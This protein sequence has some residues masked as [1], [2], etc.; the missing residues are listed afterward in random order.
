MAKNKEIMDDAEARTLFKRILESRRVALAKNS[1]AD[2]ITMAAKDAANYWRALSHHTVT[3]AFQNYLSHLAN[4]NYSGVS[5][6]GPP[7]TYDP[8]ASATVENALMYALEEDDEFVYLGLPKDVALKLA[9]A[10]KSLYFGEIQK[11]IRPNKKP[12]TTP[13]IRKNE[14]KHLAVRAVAY[15]EGQ[16]S[17]K[18]AAESDVGRAFG[19]GGQAIRKWEQS[20]RKNEGVGGLHLIIAFAAGADDAGFSKQDAEK[21]YT[22]W[23]RH[24]Q[25]R[26]KDR[27]PY[28]FSKAWDRRRE[29]HLGKGEGVFRVG[30]FKEAGRHFQEIDYEHL[31]EKW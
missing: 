14:L 12:R 13:I 24:R 17:K 6:A 7:K 4:D 3:W 15:L 31:L 21:K 22:T 16:G 23:A 8:Q 25:A 29:R 18:A 28:T 30:Q 9:W 2:Q 5:Y 20:Y 1:T 11:I 26:L 10:F 27:L 19:I